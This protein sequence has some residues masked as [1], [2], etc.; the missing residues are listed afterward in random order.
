MQELPSVPAYC[1]ERGRALNELA[2]LLAAA[3]RAGEARETWNYAI[4][5]QEKLVAEFADQPAYRQELARSL[6]N[7]GILEVQ[8]GQTARAEESFQRAETLFQEL[9]RKYPNLPAYWQELIGVQQNLANLLT[10]AE[11]R[12]AED[13]WSRL[14]A[15]QKMRWKRFPKQESFGEELAQVLLKAGEFSVQRDKTEKGEA[16]F[17]DAAAE[18]RS[19]LRGDP[20]RPAWRQ[21]LGRCL[22]GLAELQ[23]ANDDVAAAGSAREAAALLPPDGAEAIRTARVFARCAKLVTKKSKLSKEERAKKEAAYAAEAVAVLRRVAQ[24]GYRDIEKIERDEAFT[25]LRERPDFQKLVRDLA[26]KKE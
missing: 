13:A 24:A 23:A 12:E 14:V 9:T 22:L 26:G 11:R 20:R 15:S 7:R 25:A 2:M 6:C 21:G 19:L 18:Y 3:E 1:Q 16:Y 10:A 4:G 17:T 8:T 5:V